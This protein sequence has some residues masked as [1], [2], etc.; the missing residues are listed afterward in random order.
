MRF[1]CRSL[2]LA[3][4]V[5]V[6]TATKQG[7]HTN[8]TFPRCDS[9][10]YCEGPLLKTVQL[11]KLYPD[12]KTFVDKPTSKPLDQ[13]IEAFEAMGDN[14]STDSIRNFVDAN[15]LEEGTELQPVN[16]SVKADLPLLDKIDDLTYR[17]WASQIHQYWSNLTFKFDLNQLCDGCVSSI[18]PVKRPF[19]VPGGR[20]REFYY[21][22]SYFVIRGLLVSELHNEAKD[23]LL[24]FLDFVEEYGFIPNG[25]RIY[26][27]N[28]SQPPFLV[29]MIKAYY[30]AT[31][32]DDFIKQALPT[33]DKEY[34]F[35]MANKSIDVNGHTLNQYRV[36]NSSPRPESYLEDYTTAQNVTDKARLYGNLATG[37]E[38]G[39]DYT[40]RWFRYKD[41]QDGDY[42]LKSLNNDHIVPVDLNALMWN[43][44]ATLSEWH[45]S[46]RKKK[47]YK[48]QAAKR[49]EA[50]KEV[51]WDEE[52]VSF[53]DYN[54]TSN[55]LNREFTPATLYP[56]WL[57]AHHRLSKEQMGQVLAQTQHWLEAYPGILTT[58]VYNT[59]Q[60][61][62]FPNGWP[63]LQYIAL[64]AMRNV[65]DVTKDSSIVDMIHA[66]ADRYLASA[67]CSWYETGGFVPGILQQM[68]N[69]TDV[70]HMFEKFEVTVIGD[71]GGG[72]E[73]TVQAGFGWTNG[74]ALWIFDTFSSGFSAPDCSDRA[75]L[76]FPLSS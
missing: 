29:E 68:P 38:S 53:Y 30:E 4:I 51:L 74:V 34:S 64:R 57:G 72:G 59:S 67:F 21:W 46:S 50:M 48:R 22:D 49:I 10:I 36:L 62:D 24:N 19:V 17:G 52:D 6:T 73:Y 31:H 66:L 65:Y 15:F 25:A 14:P 27:L 45:T 47:Y 11:A 28:R 7:Q 39:W 76:V 75:D 71:A 2:L 9:P 56:F 16:L 63:P 70:G 55:G 5:V 20:F 12:S 33:L 43:M 42:L 1:L 60:Q 3:A 69:Q 35:W 61:W 37:A 54:I 32:D 58:S 26:Y 41:S 44:E 23:M 13:V 18:L 40:S 8:K